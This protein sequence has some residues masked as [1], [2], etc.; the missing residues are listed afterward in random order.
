VLGTIACVEQVITIEGKDGFIPQR[1]AQQA[2][3]ITTAYFALSIATS[4]T[5]STL[6]T[7]RIVL[8]Q[9]FSHNAGIQSST[10]YQRII[11]VVAESAILYSITLLSYLISTA[12]RGVVQTYFQSVHSQVVVSYSYQHPFLFVSDSTPQGLAPLLIIYRVASGYSRPTSEW[13]AGPIPSALLFANDS[14]QRTN[15]VIRDIDMSSDGLIPVGSDA[16]QSRNQTLPT[17]GGR[18]VENIRFQ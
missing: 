18:L 9:R 7:L 2:I 17:T 14:E 15:T 12:R 3:D 16:S 5:T 11:E 8:L 4:L 13:S 1:F 10:R 6:I